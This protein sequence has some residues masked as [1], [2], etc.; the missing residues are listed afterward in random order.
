[1]MTMQEF[2]QVNAITVTTK[3]VDSNPNMTD[4]PV[5][6]RHWSVLFLRTGTDKKMI[7]MFSQ[8]SAHTEPP[9][10]V[11]VLDCLASDAAGWENAPSFDVWAGEYGYDTD[12][13]KAERTFNAV[14][15]QSQKLDAFLSQD[16]YETLLWHTERE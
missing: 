4:M 6:S 2:I 7:V 1:M 10:A 8:G 15:K 14:K 12:S 5:D 3:Q 9:T 11:D 13:R 16:Q